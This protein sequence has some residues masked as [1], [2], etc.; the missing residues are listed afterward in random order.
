MLRED[1]GCRRD[2]GIPSPEQR[3]AALRAETDAGLRNDLDR[4]VEGLAARVVAVETAKSAFDRAIGVRLDRE[5]RHWT[6]IAQTAY[7]AALDAADAAGG[8]APFVASHA[9]PS[10]PVF[11]AAAG[12]GMISLHPGEGGRHRI[13]F[14]LA[15]ALEPLA[16]ATVEQRSGRGC[17]L[18]ED[19]ESPALSA[20]RAAIEEAVAALLADPWR[21]ALSELVDRCV[22]AALYANV[23]VSRRIEQ[24]GQGTAGTSATLPLLRG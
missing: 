6:G 3:I 13:E 1:D 11:Q 9:L 16:S 2:A 10:K 17:I 14:R 5:G 22:E 21:A 8:G 15:P 12:D 20:A 18:I 4:A 19:G 7:A 23:V 24:E